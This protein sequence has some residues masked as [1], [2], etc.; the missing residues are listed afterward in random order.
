MPQESKLQTRIRK[1]LEQTH[2]VLKISLCNKPG[3]PDLLVHVGDEKVKYIEV[4]SKGKK[5]EPL[6][7]HRHKELQDRGYQVFVID[8]WECYLQIKFSNL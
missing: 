6:Q 4:K 5:P 7:L 3:F 1:D 8:T 2:Y